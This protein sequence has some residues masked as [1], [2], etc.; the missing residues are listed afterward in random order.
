MV[1]FVDLDDP[2]EVEHQQHGH[3]TPFDMRDLINAHAARSLQHTSEKQTDEEEDEDDR[4]HPN[5]NALSAVLGNYPIISEIAR[6]LDLNSLHDLSRTCRQFRANLLQHRRQLI[7]QTLRCVSDT[8]DPAW[9]S[10]SVLREEAD[11][12]WNTHG[13]DGIRIPRLTSGRVGTCARDMV[14]EC[15]RCGTVVCRNCTMKAPSSTALKSRHRRLCRTCIRAPLYLHTRT[16]NPES[17]TEYHNDSSD[18][19]PTHNPPLY[20]SPCS[21]PSQ[22]WICT[23]CSTTLRTLDTSYMR[24][25]T[26]RS[27]YSTH[28]HGIGTGLGTGIEGVQCGRE[29]HCLSARTIFKEIECDAADTRTGG[30]FLQEIEGIG[31]VVKKKVKRRLLV[32]DVVQEFEDEREG[33]KYLEREQEGVDRSWCSWC[34]RVVLSKKDVL[35]VG[36]ADD[37][38]AREV[39]LLGRASDSDLSSSSSL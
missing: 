18:D 8:P 23:P 13:P 17:D 27:R 1:V 26:W 36:N 12:L 35:R 16:T 22:V 15:R 28:L 6:H 39:G 7:L 29:S 38:S 30:Y 34:A 10:E 33:G 20:R 37:T 4:E 25:W 21:C 19:F 24:A 9:K 14:G 3:N 5:L 11:E 32:G 2:D 31:G